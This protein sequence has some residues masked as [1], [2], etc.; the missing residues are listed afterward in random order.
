MVGFDEVLLLNPVT[1]DHLYENPGTAVDPITALPPE[2]KD[3]S[4]PAS[5]VQV[6]AGN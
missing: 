2:Q 4:A 5:V 1:G 3:T 6:C